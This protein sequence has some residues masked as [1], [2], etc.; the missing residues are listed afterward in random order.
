MTI[1]LPQ[2]YRFSAV[3]A[4][5]K[6]D[7]LL[8]DL[9]L[10]VSDI[11]ASAAGVFTQNIVCGAPVQYDR[12][13]VP[14]EG[15]RCVAANSRCANACTGENGINDAQEMADFASIAACGETG[16]ALVMSTGVIGVK[17]PMDKIR[18]GIT[19]AAACL[20]SSEKALVN[21]ARGIMTTDTAEKYVTK[22][23]KLDSDEIITI[24][25][26]CKGAAMMAP[27]MAT[28]L[29]VIF[30]DA[31]IEC[32]KAQKLLS[33]AAEI[34]FN[35]ISVEGHTS[36]SDTLL[37]LA[38]GAAVEKKLSGENLNKFIECLNDLCIELAIKIPL[39]GEG[40]THLITIT[41]DGCA[42][43]ADAKIIAKEIAN[44]VLVKTAIT[45][46]DPN[47][48]RVISAAGN[49]GIIFDI[50]K[51]SF[52]LN[53]FELFKNGEPQNFDKISVSNSIKNNRETIFNLTFGEG[54]AK[55]KF[56]TTDLTTEYIR[57]NSDY[58]T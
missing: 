51:L 58:T 17:L 40:V 34:S 25:G 46:A 42:S 47:W 30:T 49:S 57:L 29:A 43:T 22:Q 31:A 11:P 9:S 20:E 28:M 12:S 48:G 8:L 24:A 15:I 52:Q 16:K 6:S 14:C 37:F 44:D 35:A 21:F 36:T 5:L 10:L 18:N 33:D 13:R 2:G 53:G 23:I 45:G 54:N 50:K 3:Y 41:I 4:G 27:N 1:Y 26:I 56:W 19:K 39:D 55:T 32:E 7:P 38:N